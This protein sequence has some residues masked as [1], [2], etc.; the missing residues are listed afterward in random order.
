M[1]A[2]VS[3]AE[4]A[5]TAEYV[6]L[7]TLLCATCSAWTPTLDV[8]PSFRDVNTLTAE[9]VKRL[10]WFFA[11]EISPLALGDTPYGMPYSGNKVNPKDTQWMTEPKKAMNTALV[12]AAWD[13]ADVEYADKLLKVGADPNYKA[14]FLRHQ[15]SALHLA[16]SNGNSKLAALLVAK[17]GN[18]NLRSGKGTPLEIAKR[19]GF[20]DTVDAMLKAATETTSP[21]P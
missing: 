13:D 10:P 18:M 4:M 20:T 17:G 15:E 1:R 8:L 2:T 12:Q 7:A 5:R 16:A 14:G 11:L 21:K 19:K 9:D 3:R 6:L